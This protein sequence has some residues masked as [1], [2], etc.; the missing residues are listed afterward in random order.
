M[1]GINRE[2]VRQSVDAQAQRQARSLLRKARFAALGTIEVGDGSPSVSRVSI[3]TAMSGAPGFLISG[4]SA[5]TANL[6]ADKRCSLL[7]GEPGKGDP[8]AHPRMTI[9]GAANKLEP[10]PEKDAFQ[11]RY[12]MR[13]PK[14]SLYAGFADFSFWQMEIDR[15]YLNGGF[16]KA[17]TLSATDLLTPPVSG[18]EQVEPG[19]IAHMNDDHSAAVERYAALAGASGSGWRMTC[20]DPEGI[21]LAKDDQTARLWFDAPLASAENLRSTLA[22]LAKANS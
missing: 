19:A 13:H 16:G 4:L 14:A 3:A 12:L 2:S 17:F 6:I 11:H 5:H 8:L 18:L 1:S 20:L 21:D 15:A 9:I 7:V 10:G 22:A